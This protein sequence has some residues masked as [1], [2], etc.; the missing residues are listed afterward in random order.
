MSFGHRLLFKKLILYFEMKIWSLPFFPNLPGAI[1]RAG[2]VGGRGWQSTH[3]KLVNPY[4]YKR[5][6]KWNQEH[7]CSYKEVVFPVVVAFC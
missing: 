6:V 4:F 1:H 3:V 7:Q 5:E 2:S